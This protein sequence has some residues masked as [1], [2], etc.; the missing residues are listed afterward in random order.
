MTP[1]AVLRLGA[2]TVTMLAHGNN[3]ATGS[4]EVAIIE[5]P[6]IRLTIW[7]PL[8]ASIS[9]DPAEDQVSTGGA[10][11]LIHELVLIHLM[12]LFGHAPESMP[13]S[14]IGFFEMCVVHRRLQ[15]WTGT[16]Q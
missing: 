1:G 9:N 8:A 7:A 4:S 13:R 16:W 2:C 12:T 14:A 10:A 6:K 11:H 15:G 3:T 5:T